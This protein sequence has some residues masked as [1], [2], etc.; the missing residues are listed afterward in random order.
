MKIITLPYRLAGPVREFLLSREARE[1][2]GV[3]EDL[4]SLR[5]TLLVADMDAAQLLA[6]RVNS[7]RDVGRNPHSSVSPG[8]ILAAGILHE[9][10]HLLVMRLREEDGS[11]L[12]VPLEQVAASLGESRLQSF[13]VRFVSNFP[14]R[15]VTGDE[16]ALAYL[17]ASTD[18]LE[19]NELAFEELLLLEI[20]RQNPALER[21]RELFTATPLFEP[22]SRE[23]M[24]RLLAGAREGDTS[25]DEE[26]VVRGARNL[27]ELLEAPMRNS[28]TTL[29]GQ[30]QY[31]REHW[32][33]LLGEAGARLLELV[34][35][36]Q[37]VLAEENKPTFLGPAPALEPLEEDDLVP[38][39]ELDERFSQDEPWM[40]EL[41]L[42]AKSTYVWLDQLSR[43]YGREISS[44]DQIPGEE[45]DELR[46]RGFNGLWLIGIWE[47]SDA[48][49]K[50]KQLRGQPEALASAYAINDYRIAPEL[51]AEPALRE[52]EKLAAQRGMRLASDMV[53]NHT[54]IDSRWIIE[55]PDWFMQLSESPFP[56]YSFDGPDLSSDPRVGIYLEDHYY[57]SS[58]A[59][60][61]FKRV[62]HESGEERYIYHGNDGTAMPWNDTAQ[63]DYLNPRVRE[64]VIDTIVSVAKRF[65]VIRFDAAM[66]LARRHVR[67][68]WYPKPGEGGAI[69]SRARYGSMSDSQFD[70][71]MPREFWR[72]VV[73]AVER[74]APGTLLLAEAFWMMEA[75]FVRHLG[76]HRVYNSAFM[77]MMKREATGEY[78]TLLKRILKLEPRILE[79]FVNFMNNPD[80]DT[81]V[82]QFGKGDKYFGVA[83]VMATMPGLP[84]FGHGQVE[85]LAEKYGMEFRRA[86][87][88]ERVDEELVERHER[89]LSPLLHRRAQFA[90][91]DGFELFDFEGQGGVDEE[92]L[93][94]GTAGPVLVLFNNRFGETSGVVR[95]GAPKRRPDGSTGSIDLRSFLGPALE[96]A[97]GRDRG[98]DFIVCRD[99]VT[100]REYL[101]TW[102]QLQVGL[103][104]HLGAYE[105]RVLDDFRWV[106]DVDEELLRAV[107][108][109][110]GSRG[111]ASLQ[112][113]LERTRSEPVI[114]AW[115]D[116]LSVPFLDVDASVG[117]YGDFLAAVRE[118]EG[119]D[120]S[121]S[122]SGARERFRA[123]V[124][125]AT[126]FQYGPGQVPEA[127]ER[128]A[129]TV[130]SVIGLLPL[131][132]G[133]FERFYLEDALLSGEHTTGDSFDPDLI[134]RVIPAVNVALRE[135][136]L[137]EPAAGD[138]SG[139]TAGAE[140]RIDGEPSV[141]FGEVLDFLHELL[142]SEEGTDL[143]GV[144]RWEGE[145]YFDRDAYRLL[146]SSYLFTLAAIR[147]SST[148]VVTGL[149]DVLEE[150]AEFEEGSQYRLEALRAGQRP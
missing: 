64:A 60:V 62:D 39:A 138:D 133:T 125:A 10:Q 32:L 150:L 18:G 134:T 147:G 11:L 37:D 143:L 44:L 123:L 34:L 116:F 73:Q 49:R 108:A 127:F 5:G 46:A 102:S 90:S 98:G 86:R 129:L 128:C 3:H 110:V 115:D 139:A 101:Y 48:S 20:A 75:Y 26:Q 4:L 25:G 21:L 107:H 112:G 61:V 50:I 113:E 36:G 131:E 41:V 91:V 38:S 27:I 29:F 28:P 42:V 145:E 70:R 140:Y 111:V 117:A 106:A 124:H 119:E 77:H 93:A 135:Q 76:L 53:P 19:H 51:G 13:L 57:D 87:R 89:Q 114:S 100:E 40:K 84:M 68:L 63:L 12:R 99:R 30:L 43:K 97:G 137:E 122:S 92:V 130:Q 58:D 80:E 45:L 66:T 146:A 126:A 142:Q 56:G 2:Y 88:R 141:Q 120:E 33:P 7:V 22:E 103:P 14:P 81:A 132:E 71:A 96:A 94:Y 9:L 109:R 16:G 67:R 144:N 95:N 1:R 23:V 6:H 31:A 52:L 72:E 65:P 79:R 54:G 69:P 78:R 59:A 83:T 136:L 104:A 35:F 121:S 85:G 55:Q 82:L 8:E 118:T 105:H 17:Q 24:G 148:G 149:A 47:R 74:E 15:G